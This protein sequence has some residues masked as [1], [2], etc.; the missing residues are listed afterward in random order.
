MLQFSRKTAKIF[1]GLTVAGIPLVLF[2]VSMRGGQLQPAAD[3][4]SSQKTATAALSPYIEGH[5]H[6]N[7]DDAEGS[8]EAA[9]SAMPRENAERILFLPAPFAPGDRGVFDAEA[10]LPAAKKHPDKISVLGGGGSLNIMIQESVQSGDAGPEVQR[11]FKERAEQILREGA[12]GFGEMTAEHFA[13]GTAY[14]YAPAD[15]PLFLL[16]A[17]ISAEH[18]AP[19]VLHMEAVP[20]DMPLPAGLKSPPN[21]PKLHENISAFERLLSHNPRARIIWAHLGSD[22]TGYRTPDLCRR[23]LDAHPNLYMEIKVDPL[24]LGK[25]PPMVDGKIKPE[26]RDLFEDF[27]SRFII[28]TDQHYGPGEDPFKGPQRWQTVVSLVNQLPPGLRRKILEENAARLYG[29]NGD[30]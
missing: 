9:L 11:K 6:L 2:V 23:L 28:G 14:Q 4:S 12:V 29:F 26:W 15:H 24:S 18:G 16:L 20:Q 13:G 7:A 10:I 27:P 3:Q 19:V 5:S 21:P 1:L 25:N 8:I 30:M 22:N 17:D